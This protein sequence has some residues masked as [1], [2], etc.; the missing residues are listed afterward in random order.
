MPSYRILDDNQNEITHLEIPEECV[1]GS[2]LEGIPIV[3]IND[4]AF[5]NCVNLKTLDLDAITSNIQIGYTTAQGTTGA[6]E[7]CTSLDTIIFPTDFGTITIVGAFKGCTSLT[8]LDFSNITS[9]KIQLDNS[10]L[11]GSGIVDIDTEDVVET[12]GP[13]AF[14]DCLSLNSVITEAYYFGNGAF[15][16]SSIK[17][18]T[19]N[20]KDITT[21][22]AQIFNNCPNLDTI[23]FN[24]TKAEWYSLN[25]TDG[26]EIDLPYMPSGWEDG[27]YKVHCT[28]GDT[29]LIP[30]KDAGMY[31]NGV[32]TSWNDLVNNGDITVTNGE[33]T[34]STSNISGELVI[35]DT[36]TTIGAQAFQ[37]NQ[38]I[39]SVY[40]PDSIVNIG[41]AAFNNCQ[42]L[43]DI[44]LSRV[45]GTIGVGAFSSCY[46]VERIVIGSGISAIYGGAF[47]SCVNVTELKFINGN[48]RYLNPGAAIPGSSDCF[49]NLTSLEEVVLPDNLEYIKSNCFDGCTNLK[50]VTLG[51]NIGIN[52]TSNTPFIDSYAF[53][54][55]NSITD[56]YYNGNIDMWYADNTRN[57][58]SDTSLRRILNTDKV[59]HCLNGDCYYS[60]T[61]EQLT[62]T[63]MSNYGMS[64][65]N[66]KYYKD[67]IE[68]DTID[69]RT[70][71]INTSD[72]TY[73][74]INDIV[75]GLFAGVTNIKEV[76][77]PLP[78]GQLKNTV[79]NGCSLLEKIN[80]EDIYKSTSAPALDALS[81]TN[82]KGTLNTNGI[83]PFIGNLVR[84]RYNSTCFDN[85]ALRDI[86][87]LHLK[88]SII[89]TN[90]VF[91]NMTNLKE[92]HFG[93]EGVSNTVE[94]GSSVN[95]MFY[96]CGNQNTE[97]YFEKPIAYI[98]GD[99]INSTSTNTQNFWNLFKTQFSQYTSVIHCTD[100][101][102]DWLGNTI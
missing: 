57:G 52:G 55:C 71:Y 16:G 61:G 84:K 70:G 58:N 101:D 24:G 26:W 69:M 30:P 53:N 7:G 34:A 28:D 60:G 45:S 27:T 33:I 39:T 80:I 42:N 19:F 46:S 54:N 23:N 37:N 102:C 93:I 85:N 90:N 9:G 59:L 76:I 40:F 50:K 89:N 25:K 21:L 18:I 44:N 73:H 81:G 11:L 31:N 63:N 38:N 48:L 83:N 35:P 98:Q 32:F 47:E 2:E 14:K 88:T 3:G 62:S 82:L 13:N 8:D 95:N 29:P 79:F 1:V 75:A 74:F 91:N 66:N 15:I 4:G 92:V 12:I 100:G 41:A 86:E 17:E 64:I 77:L 22:G 20:N 65:S 87:Y 99:Y 43:T 10:C 67:G 49:G 51:K 68:S 6:F 96:N 97:I 36:V 56:I 5:T 78:M 94:C 72:D